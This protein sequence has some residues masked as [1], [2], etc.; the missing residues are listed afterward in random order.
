[1]S[2]KYIHKLTSEENE[3]LKGAVSFKIDR[4]VFAISI[5]ESVGTTADLTQDKLR[6]EA[7]LDKLNHAEI[8]R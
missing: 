1:M 3:L 5:A 7:L 4:L 6:F 2:V 8:R